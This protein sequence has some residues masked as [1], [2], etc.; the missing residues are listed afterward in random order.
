MIGLFRW[1]TK[2]SPPF[3]SA[4]RT[5]FVLPNYINNKACL[6]ASYPSTPQVNNFKIC[7]KESRADRTC[8]TPYPGAPNQAFSSVS[9]FQPLERIIFDDKIRSELCYF[10]NVPFEEE[11]IKALA[12]I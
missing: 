1:S 7:S 10:P 5:T 4:H 12:Q 6:T 8:R 2:R 11:N 3:S 9:T